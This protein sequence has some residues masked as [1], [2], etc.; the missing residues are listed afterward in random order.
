MRT[1]LTAGLAL[2]AALAVGGAAGATPIYIVNDIGLVKSFSGI[3]DG[4]T[5]IAGNSF[6][7]G[8][9][10]EATI[11]NYGTYQAFTSTED[12]MV[13][14]VNM[15]GDVV[16]WASIT[17]WLNNDNPTTEATGSYG[18][19][20]ANN[21]G[22]GSIH[23]ASVYPGGFYV[24]YEGGPDIDGD[25][26]EYGS[27]DDFINNTNATISAAPYGGNLLNFFYPSEDAP[28]NN[29]GPNPDGEA[30]ANYFQVTGGGTIEGFN[31]LDDYIAAPANA[32]FSQGGF[33]AG[34][35]SGFAVVIPEPASLGLLAAAGLGL[36]RR[37]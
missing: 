25:I 20:T 12:G 17:S 36:I 28:S 7:A 9:T 19:E 21:V 16:S 1:Q 22:A 14:G 4:A 37:R 2:A 34:V 18:A 32:T 26:G 31:T 6:A 27:L 29:T 30:G 3:T 5:P 10:L 13:Y 23:G 33:G 24:V 15:G 8:G 35:R 11:P